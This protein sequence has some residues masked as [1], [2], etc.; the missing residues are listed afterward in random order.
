MPDGDTRLFRLDLYA[1]VEDI[2]TELCAELDLKRPEDYALDASDGAGPTDTH[3][4]THTHTH[5]RTTVS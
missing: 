4:H 1:T 3:T 5:T 2:I